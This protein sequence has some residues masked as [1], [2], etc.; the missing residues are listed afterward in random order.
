MSIR[1]VVEKANLN[2]RTLR[3]ETISIMNN[4]NDLSML[5]AFMKLAVGRIDSWVAVSKDQIQAPRQGYTPLEVESALE[6]L[7]PY[8]NNLKAELYAN[9]YTVSA[10]IVRKP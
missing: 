8:Y 6:K 7:V 5:Q 4:I 2:G 3:N 1:D 10:K 9:A